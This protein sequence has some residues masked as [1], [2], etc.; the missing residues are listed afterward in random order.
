[1]LTDS[2]YE[3]EYNRI[4]AEHEDATRSCQNAIATK[5]T[6]NDEIKSSLVSE[7]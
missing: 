1:M 4:M 6:R 2:D 5:L 7:V 3:R